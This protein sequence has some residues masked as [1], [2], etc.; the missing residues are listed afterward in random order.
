MLFEAGIDEVREALAGLFD[1]D[2]CG[3]ARTASIRFRVPEP[4]VIVKRSD[5]RNAV[6]RK[7]KG[8][9]SEKGLIVWATMLLL[10]DAFEPDPSDREFVA[11]WLNDVSFNGC[12]S[13]IIKTLDGN[14]AGNV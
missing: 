7:L 11:D 1:F 3:S 2:F 10:N 9:V 14:H 5:I 12:S 13:E 8:K 4:G 6:E